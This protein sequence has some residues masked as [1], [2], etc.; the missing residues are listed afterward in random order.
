MTI[1][2]INKLIDVKT[3]QRAH[4]S[5]SWIDFFIPNDK[6]YTIQ[7]WE[8]VKIPLGVRALI[9]VGYD[10]TFVNKSG[11]ASKT[12]LI[13]WACLVDQGYTW[14]LVVNLINTSENEIEIK[15]GQKIIQ[16]VIR[17]VEY[18]QVEEY[19]EKDF[20][21]EEVKQL[22]SRGSKWFWSTWV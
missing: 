3:P 5:D 13:T 17:P 21:N 12:W 2:K 1:L 19:D 10:L 6:E 8:N 15:K 18:S 20:A 4:A 7:P 9:P 16:W 22:S 14:E 11:I